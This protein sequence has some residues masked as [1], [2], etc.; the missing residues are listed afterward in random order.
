MQEDPPEGVPEWVVTYGDMM[1]LLLTFFIMLV[2][3]SEVAADAKY[4]A[5]LDAL[6]KYV[7]YRTSPLTPP[8]KNFPLN[9]LIAKIEHLGSFVDSNE[10]N[11]GG[12]RAHAP[13]GNSL[14]VYRTREGDPL[15]IGNAITFEPNAITLSSQAEMEVRSIAGQLAGK[16]NKIE[17]RAHA[18][19]SESR[20]RENHDELVVLTYQRSR[21]VYKYLKQL[22]IATERMRLTAAADSQ[23]LPQTDDFSAMQHDRVEVLSLSAYT[24]EFVGSKVNRN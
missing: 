22:D 13:P 1:S 23:P 12:I 17:I 15:R 5:V 19:P 9:A 24:D 10:I 14:R 18:R 11:Y 7:G 21:A 16:P 2:S 6:Q 20:S 8:G 4:R 3:M